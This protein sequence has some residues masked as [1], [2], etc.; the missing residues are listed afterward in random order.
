[1]EHARQLVSCLKRFFKRLILHMIT[2]A[3]AV[4]MKGRASLLRS[5]T[6]RRMAATRAGALRNVPRRRLQPGGA[7][8]GEVEMNPRVPGEPRL[9]R[10]MLV[11]TVVV[12]NEMEVP[13]LRRLPIDRVQERDELGARV[14][15]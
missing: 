2:E 14:A 4:Q 6:S 12:E 10:R 11:R 15:A 7:G 8:R 5:P 3:E 9:H 13:V 1:E